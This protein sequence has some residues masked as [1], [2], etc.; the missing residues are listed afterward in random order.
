MT[1]SI[2]AAALLATAGT[3]APAICLAQDT[4]P[5][6][7]VEADAAEGS[8]MITLPAPDAEGVAAQYLYLAQIET[9]LG[10]A[11]VGVDRGATL[12]NGIVRFRRIGSKV[13]VEQVNNRFVATTGTAAEQEGVDQSFP[14]AVLW[15]GDIE[16]TASDGSFTFDFAPFLSAD[17]FGLA[18]ALGTSDNPYAFDADRSVADPSQV[19]VFPEN[20][21][22]AALMS[23]TAERPTAGL[24]NVSPNGSDLT[25]WVRHSLVALPD[26]PI[27]AR[28]DPYGFVFSQTTYDYSAPLGQPMMRQ[29]ALRHR[30]EKVD[31]SAARSPV[32][33]PI[34]FYIDPA[35]P[36]PVRQALADGVGWWTEA[37]DAAGLVDAFRVEILPEGADPLDARYNVVN[38]VNRATRGWS[39]GSAVADPRSGEVMKGAVM[40]GSLRVR[41]DIMIFQALVGAGMTDTGAPNDPVA[42]ALA[43]IRQLGAHEVGHALGFSHNFAASSQG[44]YSV[45]D[46]PAPRIELVDGQLSLADAYGS[47]VGEW[48]RFVVAYLYG[49]Q[50]DA[51]ALEMAREAQAQG[52]RFVGDGDAR[53]FDTANPEGALWD[54]FG[55]PVAELERVMDVRRAALARFDVDAIPAGQDLASLRRAFVPIW[56]LHRYQTEAAAKALGGVIA[57]V[58]LAGSER[59]P[60][61]VPASQQKAAL[62][63][64]L[65]ALSVEALSVPQRLQ[66]LLSYGPGSFGDYQTDI[67]VMPT[68]GGPVFDSLRAAEI[69]AIH[70]LD[71]L[72]DPQRLNRL[73]MQSASD[74][75]IPSALDLAA[76][77]IAHADEVGATGAVGQRIATTIAL[78]LAR[79]AREGELSRPVAMQIEGLIG[80]WAERL[81]DTRRTGER[82]DW[83]R[84]LGALLADRDALETALEAPRTEVPPGMPIG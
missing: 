67:E 69:G 66:P 6:V 38:W 12:T 34:T 80:S 14:T 44:R 37:F 33:E 77:L 10:S 46:Y 7:A 72:L 71:S 39:Y 43:R 75:G 36:E 23:F 74:A 78:D 73:E 31:P 49:A 16:E 8:I 26:D 30:L 21:E 19:R 62:D 1:K 20:A 64:L 52:L 24:R 70:V 55:D 25:M 11:A 22:F 17:R 63:A 42:A 45:M 40:L 9:G 82:A 32:R 61:T 58:A 76:R 47:G 54:D 57:P 18:R 51:E 53:G 28:H 35:A 59:L 29:L 41:Q 65:D 68:A 15:L 83:Q 3:L 79:T 13:A 81:S 27:P 56:L 84:G 48:D 60:E 50:S 4:V 2:L 5:L